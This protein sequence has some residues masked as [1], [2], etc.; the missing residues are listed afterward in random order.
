VSR[1]INNKGEIRAETREAVIAVIARLG[2]RPS[3]IARG[4]AT[5]RTYTIGLLVPDIANPF[6]PDI[7]RGVE[8]VA[9]ECGYHVFLCNTTEAPER[10][11]AVLR[12]LEGKRVDGVIVG[13]AR[14]PDE[15]LLALLAG[16]PAA[17]LVNRALPESG[18]GCVMVDTRLGAA[19]AIGHLLADGRRHIAF[20]AGPPASQSAQR[21]LVGY[22]DTLGAAGLPVD[23]GLI[24]RCPPNTA[25]GQ[26]AARALLASRPDVDA[27]YCYNDLIALG[28]LQICAEDGRRVP[29]DV[30]IVGFDDILLA[31]V[32][33]PALTTLHVPK[34]EIGAEAARMLLAMIEGRATPGQVVIAPRL[35][36]RTS[37][38]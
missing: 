18:A 15:Q 24:V 37:A 30:A 35:V 34:Y 32:I 16:H 23:E 22:A 38:P 6:W 8:N 4:L 21:H 3:S 10:E 19:A 36:V 12:L 31:Q 7:A 14:Q 33:T 9:W 11:E 26:T 27:I 29:E 2:Y 28:A 17:V 25:G 20:L 1:V 5:N 13:G